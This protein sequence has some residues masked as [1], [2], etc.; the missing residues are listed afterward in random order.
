[1]VVSIPGARECISL[2]TEQV[3]RMLLEVIPKPVSMDPLS[4]DCSELMA[5]RLRF[6]PSTRAST[7]KYSGL[8]KQERT[9]RISL[10]LSSLTLV[11]VV[12]PI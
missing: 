5:S 9:E 4:K 2:Y 1:M 8:P 6:T 10:S 12:A 11:E 3:L 7:G